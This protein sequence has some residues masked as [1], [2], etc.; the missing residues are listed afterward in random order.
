MPC[1]WRQGQAGANKQRRANRHICA[2]YGTG[3]G[4][5]LQGRD[6]TRTLHNTCATTSLYLDASWH[7][8]I[9]AAAPSGYSVSTISVWAEDWQEADMG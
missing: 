7:S 4:I 6:G 2:S 1:P 5:A 3:S 8:Y 9:C